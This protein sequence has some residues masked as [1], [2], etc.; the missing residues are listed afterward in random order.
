MKVH[1]LLLQRH[2]GSRE[3]RRHDG[4]VAVDRRNTRWCSDALEIACDNGEKVRVAFALDCCDRKA[5]GHVATTGG[6]TAEDIRDLMVATVENGFGTLNRLASP[7]EWL[8][9]NGSPYVAKDT[10]RFAHD[11]GL[12]PRT[13]PVSSPQLNGLAEAF[14]RTGANCIGFSRDPQGLEVSVDCSSGEPTLTGSHVLLAV[15]R[16]LNTDDLGLEVAAIATDARGYIKST[17]S[18]RPMFPA[19]GHWATAMAAAPSRT[20]R[21]T[22]LR[23]SLRTCSM[24]RIAE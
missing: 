17:T 4:R 14:V 11:I 7:I 1:G 19:S 24:A 15:G 3:E 10:R 12:V 2:S 21:I 13:T 5:M 18:C 8:S 22:T 6:I 20:R 23:S 9:D 16:Q